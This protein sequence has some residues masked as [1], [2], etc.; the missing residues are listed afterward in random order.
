MNNHNRQF[1]K[2]VGSIL[3]VC[4]ATSYDQI[5]PPTTVE[6]RL[7]QVWQRVGVAFDQSL[8]D[9]NNY[10]RNRSNKKTK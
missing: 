10:E 8:M 1:A 9:F 7:E 6:K 3:D 2:G 5:F 4:P